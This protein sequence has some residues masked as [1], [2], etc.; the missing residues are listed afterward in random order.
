MA[1]AVG[2]IVACILKDCATAAGVLRAVL[3][4]EADEARREVEPP[5]ATLA[6]SLNGHLAGDA[7]AMSPNG[8]GKVNGD[9]SHPGVAFGTRAQMTERRL[10]VRGEHEQ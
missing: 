1:A 2:V 5:P 7:A 8:N 3:A 9:L 10:G 6:A 4:A